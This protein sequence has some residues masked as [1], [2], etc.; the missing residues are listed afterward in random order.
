MVMNRFPLTR[1]LATMTLAAAGTAFAAPHGGPG[2]MM[3]GGPGMGRMLDQVNASAEQRAQIEQIM[4]A[5]RSDLKAQQEAG[6]AL[7]EQSMQLFSQPTVDANAAEALRQQM[8]AQHD[9]ASQ[10]M[11]QAMLEVSRVLTPEQRQQI[12]E[13]MRQRA[14]GMKD[15]QRGEARAPRS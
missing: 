10:R 11:M 14:D 8:L 4:K 12:A 6:R 13:Q 3:F 5:A 2:P 15:R 9:R 7:R 1:L